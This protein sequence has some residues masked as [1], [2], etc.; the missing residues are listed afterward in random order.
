MANCEKC[1]KQIEDGAVFCSACTG[2]LDIKPT[3][4]RGGN[5]TQ[6]ALEHEV[7]SFKAKSSKFVTLKRLLPVIVC[8]A[9]AIIGLVSII[10]DTTSS[11]VSP[12]IL[13]IGTMVIGVLV[14]ILIARR[15]QQDPFL[16]LSIGLLILTF[17]VTKVLPDYGNLIF[18]IGIT[19]VGFILALL[20][21][22]QSDHNRPLSL[23]LVILI[24]SLGMS[25][26]FP[27]ITTFLLAVSFILTGFLI[28]I[29]YL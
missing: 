1:G 29:A 7:F 11:E 2:V 28:F 23:A 20:L 27:E 25:M 22:R 9:M 8:G 10:A 16:F 12:M 17:G 6:D 5:A 26:A 14:V 3:R 24:V 18:P 21:F 4:V 13:S 19:L 15:S